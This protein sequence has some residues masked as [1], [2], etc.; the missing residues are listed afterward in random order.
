M[1]K[2]AYEDAKRDYERFSQLYDKGAVPARDLEKMAL[3]MKVREE[4]LS[5]AQAG[6][7]QA[8]AQ[9]NYTTVRAPVSGVVVR[10]MANVSEMALPGRPVIILSSTDQ[11]KF[12][13]MIPESDAG[14]AHVG[15]R[16]MVNIPSLNKTM[17]A[18]ISAVI[19]AADMATHSYRVLS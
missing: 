19:P 4:Q 2:S 6:L 14:R 11:L 5:M 12:Q 7:K 1:A 17:E 15:D 10:K 3:N 9:S 8:K 16:V 18:K 13:A